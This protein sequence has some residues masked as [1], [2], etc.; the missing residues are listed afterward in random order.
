MTVECAFYGEVDIFGIAPR[1]IYELND[2]IEETK[3]DMQDAWD[4]INSFVYCNDIRTLMSDD[5]ERSPIE[6]AKEV[7]DNCRETI[8]LNQ[9]RLTRL[10]IL[11]ENWDSCHT[12]AKDEDGRNVSLAIPIPEELMHKSFYE[13]DYIETVEVPTQRQAVEQMTVEVMDI[14]FNTYNIK[15]LDEVKKIIER[16]LYAPEAEYFKKLIVN[17][18]TV[19]PGHSQEGE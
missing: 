9:D 1:S 15:D 6:F 18:A 16:D 2:A 3:K 19:G 7:I 10:E 8:A 4:R 13:G 5:E 11:K 12:T 14:I 17:A